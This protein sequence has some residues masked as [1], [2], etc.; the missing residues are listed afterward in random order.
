MF[1]EN[2][3]VF[4]NPF[5]A[6]K[7]ILSGQAGSGVFGADGTSIIDENYNIDAPVTSTNLTLSGTLSV[8]GTSTLT[9]AV[10]SAASI[11]LG[12]GADLIGSATSDI[13]INTNKFTVAGA[14][15]NTL[16]AGTL[17]VDGNS[18]VDG[19][20]TVGVDDT[21]YDVKLFGATASKYWLW[22]ESADSVILVGDSDQTGNSQLTGTLTVGV[23]DTGHDVKLFGA[24]AGSYLLWDESA[25][26]LIVNAGT[27]DLGTSCEADAYTVGSTAGADFNGAVT[28]ITVVKGIVTAAS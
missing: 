7:I 10:A 6:D 3:I 27:A 15:G 16:I 9:G 14:T 21:G 13:T 17:D 12:A 1:K 2:R 8:T 11:T 20:I 19:T 25:D 22:D 28:N 4:K 26:Q 18:Q 5:L 24:T 23:D